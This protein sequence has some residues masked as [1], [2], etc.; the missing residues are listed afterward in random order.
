MEIIVAAFV[1]IGL[2]ATAGALLTGLVSM[3][4]GGEF[5]KLYSHQL[6]FARVG[7]QAVT[8]FCLLIAL[9]MLL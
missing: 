9:L 6:M 8:L 3:G 4:R 7:L 1:T 2:V 5:D